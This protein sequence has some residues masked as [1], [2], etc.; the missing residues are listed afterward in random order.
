M[1]DVN[2]AY[3]QL[4]GGVLDIDIV[5]TG[6]GQFDRLV[7]GG[8]AEFN[9]SLDVA[10]IAGFAP[11]LSNTFSI[12]QAGMIPLPS[13][14][15]LLVNTT[16]PPITNK[17]RW[18]LFYQ[19]TTL[20]LAVVPSLSGDF[21]G[22]GTVD[23]ADYV[24]WRKQRGQT[25]IG[26]AADGNFDQ[27]VNVVDLAIWRSQFGQFVP[28]SGAGADLPQGGTVPEPGAFMLACLAALGTTIGRPRKCATI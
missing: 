25:G 1:T 26:L 11:A 4:A 2:F 16:F 23:A 21:N 3:S 27:Q 7:V 22:S 15:N 12:V 8:L 20:T 28:G 6:L 10:T 19:P 5:G 17:L 13:Y 24:M 9:G 14:L 18:Q